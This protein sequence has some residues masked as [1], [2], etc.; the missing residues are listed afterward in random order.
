MCIRIPKWLES[1]GKDIRECTGFD[2]SRYL[3]QEVN[4]SNRHRITVDINDIK[5]FV[6]FL[7]EKVDPGYEKLYKSF[8]AKKPREYPLPPLPPDELIELVL[9]NSSTFYKALFTVL[10]E[11]GL[12]LGEALSIRIRHIKDC[13][14]YIKPCCA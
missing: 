9:K 5:R 7:M 12:R 1:L 10:Y 4:P 11:G 8:K 6:R 14:D 2:I 3:V 13:G